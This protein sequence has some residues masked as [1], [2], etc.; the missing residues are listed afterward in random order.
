MN[1]QQG[2]TCLQTTSSDAP[3]TCYHYCCTAADCGPGGICDTA[4]ATLS[5]PVKNPAD[6]I[7]ICLTST[8]T[9]APACS[10]PSTSP[11]GGTCVGG[12]SPSPDGGAG[13]SGDG[14]DGGAPDG[15]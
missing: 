4:I 7:G 6:A 11:S 15:G 10:P 1:C 12:Y 5:L 2:S 8:T 3:F 14:G 9:E 13:G